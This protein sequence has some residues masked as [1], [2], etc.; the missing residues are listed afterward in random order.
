MTAD[1]LS[2]FGSEEVLKTKGGKAIS[3]NLNK[4]INGPQQAVFDHWLIPVFVGEWMFGPKVQ[5]EKVL[6]LK[7]TV[8]KNGSYEY[9]IERKGKEIIHSGEFLELDIPNRVSLSW[10][11]SPKENLESQISAQFSSE[12]SKTRMKLTIKLPAEL[13]P[14]KDKIKDSWSAR[15]KALAE[16][17]NK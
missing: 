1:Q 7:N 15:C 4:T 2:M 5:A 9:R 16:K 8:R 11:E 12:G 3:F 10:R 14:D 17:F 6:E 13:G